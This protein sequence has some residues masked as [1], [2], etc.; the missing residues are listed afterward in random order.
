MLIIFLC[1]LPGTGKTTLAE[2]LAPLIGAAV[3]STD[4]IRKELIPKPTYTAEEK[5]L[6]YNVMLLVAKYLYRAGINCILDATFNTEKSRKEAIAKLGIK[7]SQLHIVECICP[8]DLAI[9]RLKSRKNSYSDADI[10]V[11]MKMKEIYEPVKEDHII[12][13][14]STT[15]ERNANEIKLKILNRNESQKTT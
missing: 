9:D 13:H 7:R 10:S 3:L 6:V 12:A 1:G 2:A 5:S 8:E 15:P 14:T 4:K 11:Y